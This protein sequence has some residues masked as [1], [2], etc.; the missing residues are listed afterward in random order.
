LEV[1][2]EDAWGESAREYD[3]FEKKWHFYGTVA[4]G[5]I[6][7]LKIEVGSQVLELACG[8]GA[9]T[10]K[11]SRLVGAGRVVALDSSVGMLAVAGENAS[12]E[13]AGNVTFVRGDAGEIS[14]LLA[15]QSFDFAVCNSAFW[16]FP[17]P[18]KVLAGLR[19]LLT[20]SGEFAFSV[21]SWVE[22]REGV[23]EAFRAKAREVLL[24]HGLSSESLDDLSAR[25]ARREVDLPA[26]FHSSGFEVKC[27]PFEFVVS[28][29]SRAAWRQISMFSQ[30][31][32]QSW[33]PAELDPAT[34]DEIRA[35]LDAWRRANFPREP[36]KSRWRIYVGRR[37]EEWAVQ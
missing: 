23:R 31:R 36:T 18:E 27:V 22:G 2:P 9:C 6:A 8:T 14:G 13:G 26:L 10:L 35:E 25:R 4:D 17:Q 11:L 7:N 28:L 15:G 19:A 16:H 20:P 3:S 5:T 33:L 37:A 34:Q 1:P 12:A 21:P 24:A 29:E 32:R 30:G